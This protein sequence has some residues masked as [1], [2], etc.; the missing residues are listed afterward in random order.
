M[1]KGNFWLGAVI[2][3][4]IMGFIGEPVP[5]LGPLIGGLVAGLVARG[6]YR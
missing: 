2:G 4:I 1:A 6:R 3:F 5:V